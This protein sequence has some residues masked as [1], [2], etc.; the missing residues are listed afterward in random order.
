VKV[1]LSAYACEP[2]R[3]SEP[4]VGW[5]VATHLEASHEVWVLTRANNRGA[6]EAGM[7][8]RPLSTLHVVYHD[9][10]KWLMWWKRGARGSQLYY[11]LW[12]LTAASVARRL[13]REVGFDVAHH[14]T[15]AKYWSPSLL[16]GLPV[17]YV[18]GPLGGGDSTPRPFLRQLTSRGRIYELAR[19]GARWM[20]ERDPRVRRTASRSGLAFAA[21]EATASRLRALGAADVRVLSQVALAEV[22]LV[23][24]RPTEARP[25][26]ER[27]L[28]YL[29]IGRLLDLKATELGLRAFAAAALPLASFLVIGDGPDRLR[30]QRLACELGVE[31]H[32]TFTGWLTRDAVLEHLQS[33]TALV[34]PSLH[35]SGGLVCAE[36]LASGVPVICLDLAG[37][38]MQVTDE[39]GVVVPATRPDQAVSEMAAAMR[40]ISAPEVRREKSTAAVARAAELGYEQQCRRF[41]AA[42][43]DLL[44]RRECAQ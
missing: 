21:T 28:L 30:L 14:V 31:D 1:L 27:P 5:G 7:T 38:A 19:M 3:G 4:E 20:A 15:F 6:I 18:W 26:E 35:D 36:A 13:H 8:E 39:C 34:H 22:D 24:L 9:W 23:R 32:V 2:G 25:D 41:T 11:Y 43:E 40:S 17:P 44:R 12:Q 42:Y 29:S 37:P 10:P 33:A 16:A